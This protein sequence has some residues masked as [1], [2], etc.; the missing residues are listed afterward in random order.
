MISTLLSFASVFNIFLFA[1]IFKEKVDKP[2]LVGIVLM[3]LSV[4]CM[5]I[6]LDSQE[7]EDVDSDYIYWALLTGMIAP[8]L[9]SSKHVVIRK[10]KGNYGALS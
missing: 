10:F 9:M 4:V 2:Q 3:I 6:K 5:G 7:Q 1:W 8:C